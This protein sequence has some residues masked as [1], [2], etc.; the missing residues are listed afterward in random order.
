MSYNVNIQEKKVKKEIL[1]LDKRLRLCL[2]IVIY[3]T[4]LYQINITLKSILKALSEQRLPKLPKINNRQNKT[5]RQGPK[6]IP[7]NV[8]NNFSSHT[9]SSDEL[10]ALSYGLNHQ[11]PIRNNIS[12]TTTE[13]EFFIKVYLMTYHMYL[14]F[15]L[16]R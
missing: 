4:L 12:D 7:K 13:F 15:N 10:V 8:V 16:F 5:E 9:L 11:I 14:K 6:W 2:N 3:H 1:Q